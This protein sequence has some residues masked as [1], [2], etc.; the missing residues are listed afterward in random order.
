VAQIL[1]AMLT[2][3]YHDTRRSSPVPENPRF[4]DARAAADLIADGDVVGVSGLGG[5]QRASILFWAIREAFE[6]TGHPAGLT[7]VNLGGHGGRGRA[8]GTLE[9]LGRRGLCRRLVAGHFETYRA[10]LALAA[11]GDCELQCIPQGTLALLIDALGRGADS[12]LS[13]TGVGTFVDPRVGSGSR[14]GGVGE[15]LIT[16]EGERLR[17]RIPPIDVAIFN[18]PAADRDGNIYVRGCAAIGETAELARAAKRNGGRVIANVGLIVEPGYDRVYLPADMIDAVVYHPDTEQAA[19]IF[20]RWHW[21][22]LTTE[23]T[24]PIA[25]AIAQAE[26]VNRL[27]GL[28]PRRTAAD[29]LVARLAAA[30]LAEHVAPG[31][32]VNIGTG[33]PER[34]CRALYEAGMHEKLTL[35]VES[36]AVGGVPASG[37]YFGASFSPQRIVSSAE[38]FALCY[39]R[40]DATCLG[41]L[42]VDAEGNVNVSRRSDGCVDYIGPGGFIDLTAAART[43][44]FAS[45]WTTGEQIAVA[46]DL[47]RVVRCGAP[48]FVARVREIT[49]DGRRALAAGK[50]VFYATP[51]G[52][53]ELTARGVALVRVMPGIDVRRDVLDVAAMPIV[54]P[55]SGDVPLVPLAIVTGENLVLR[56][57]DRGA[58]GMSVETERAA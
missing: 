32:R 15:Q 2:W 22:A 14:V 1:R 5:N 34:A 40:L 30:T 4:K 7:V 58:A 44:V 8:P 13:A 35:L 46:D 42:E 27:A 53:F 50:R 37:L 25:E 12:W 33:L 23:S 38:M 52:L 47:V 31:A 56:L 57:G 18:A 24:T 54:L 3:Q 29:D 26:L 21:P 28:T 11:N 39:E 6:E 36:G 9:E 17:Y 43:I 55:A 10:M 16:V 41:A 49:F 51:V 19:G 48:K 45:K 20:H